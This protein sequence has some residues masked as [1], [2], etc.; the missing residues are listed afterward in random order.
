MLHP[1]PGTGAIASE[2]DLISDCLQLRQ[3]YEQLKPT[4]KKAL[5]T[6]RLKAYELE[7]QWLDL[8]PEEEDNEEL[9]PT[10]EPIEWL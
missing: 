9:P 2:Q 3:D 4:D 7:D 6:L 10:P 8:P 5:E 1:Y